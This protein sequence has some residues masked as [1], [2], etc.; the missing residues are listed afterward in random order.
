MS[1]GTRLLLSSLQCKR[2]EGLPSRK[3]WISVVS[4]PL[5]LEEQMHLPEQ[6]REQNNMLVEECK[7]ALPQ[8]TDFWLKLQ[9]I[10]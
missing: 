9:Y 3:A 5:P 6:E 8:A 4:Q 2:I 1:G 7:K 10:D